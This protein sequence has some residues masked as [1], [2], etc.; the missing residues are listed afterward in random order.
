MRIL[1]L[2]LGTVR[3][4]VAVSDEMGWTAQPLTV[5]KHRGEKEDLDAIAEIIEEYGVGELVVGLPTN[6]NGSIGPMAEKALK[7]MDELRQ[8]FDLPVHQWD[9]RLSTVAVERTL[10][11][12]DVRR[13]KRKKVID[14]MAA[15]YI[16]QGY[17][18]LR[19]GGCK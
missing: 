12:A 4:G 15:S 7:F 19:S 5:I 17:L 10:L 8:R 14:K 6:M 13:N 16:L 1:G 18:D 3:L 2:D 9:E 11:D